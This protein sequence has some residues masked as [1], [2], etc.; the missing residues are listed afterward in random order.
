MLLRGIERHDHAN[1]CYLDSGVR[2]LRL[3]ERAPDLW[4][5]QPQEERRKLL[6]LLLLNCTFDGESLRATYRKPFCWLAEGSL[7]SI[8]RG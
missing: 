4:N 8:W 6:D 3:A 5:E 2:L 7:R 1:D